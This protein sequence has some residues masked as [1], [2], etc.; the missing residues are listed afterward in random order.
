[1]K[2][3]IASNNQKKLKELLAIVETAK[4][5][6]E[7]VTPSQLGIDINPEENGVTLEAN[8]LI[9]AKEFYL[10]AGI[11][12]IAD[13]TG[14]EVDALNG[15]PGVYSA[16]YAGE[17]ATD[18]DN[19]IKLLAELG[20]SQNRKARFRTVICLFDGKSEQFFNGVCEGRIN[21]EEKGSM[22]FGYDQLFVPS[23]YDET[24]AEMDSLVKNKISHR[25]KALQLLIEYLKSL[26]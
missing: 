25:A 12:T 1:M 13:D 6:L 7:I 8:A 11:I 22:G 26:S 19:R 9:K 3:L 14:L 21:T 16:R 2:L 4:L 10:A 23:G 15:R 20:N 24:F 18:S 17:N 5:N